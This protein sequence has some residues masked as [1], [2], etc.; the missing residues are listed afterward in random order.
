MAVKGKVVSKKTDNGQKF[1]QIA[2]GKGF[3]K[4]KPIKG[5][6]QKSNVKPVT[7]KKK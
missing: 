1:G 2:T 5:H 4:V 3:A 6:T 7:T